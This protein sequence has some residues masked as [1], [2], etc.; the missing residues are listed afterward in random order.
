MQKNIMELEVF[1]FE[2]KSDNLEVINR[3]CSLYI[4]LF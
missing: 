1:L 3:K 4:F 2:N